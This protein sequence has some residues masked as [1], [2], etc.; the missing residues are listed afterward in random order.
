[1]FAEV[2]DTPL[3]ISLNLQ[4]NVDITDL[5]PATSLEKKFIQVVSLRIS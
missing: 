2:L 3:N 4:E 5:Q 1:M